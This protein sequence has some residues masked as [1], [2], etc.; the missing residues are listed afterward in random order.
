MFN[1]GT[2]LIITHIYSK[3]ALSCVWPNRNAPKFAKQHLSW[4]N[5]KCNNVLRFGMF[6]H[7]TPE[8][9]TNC[10]PRYSQDLSIACHIDEL[11]NSI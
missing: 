1:D 6:V 2:D 5:L 11:I 10:D 4:G 9:H 7:Q 3:S 8:H